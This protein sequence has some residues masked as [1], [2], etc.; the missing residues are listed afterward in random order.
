MTFYVFF[1][2][3]H[4]FSRTVAMTSY[5]DESRPVS[6]KEGWKWSYFQCGICGEKGGDALVTEFRGTAPN[7]LIC[8]DVY[9]TLFAH[10]MQH[11]NKISMRQ[12][13]FNA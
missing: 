11:Q 9:S 13:Q 1:E 10:N 4:T 7:G 2:L 6:I 8:A 5:V 12:T 3:L